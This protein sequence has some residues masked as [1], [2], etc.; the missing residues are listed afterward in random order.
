MKKGQC[1]RSNAARKALAG[2][3][4]VRTAFVQLILAGAWDSIL[5]SSHGGKERSRRFLSGLGN[6]G[7]TPG[8][9]DWTTHG[10]RFPAN[11]PVQGA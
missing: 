11:R 6:T 3:V 5:G 7:I 2:H 10:F 9:V 4:S 1:R 8:R